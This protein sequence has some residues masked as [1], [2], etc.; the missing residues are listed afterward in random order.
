MH[1]SAKPYSSALP[2]KKQEGS[3]N[4]YIYCTFRKSGALERPLPESRPT[5][6]DNETIAS[7]AFAQVGQV[8]GANIM[9]G[10][11]NGLFAPAGLYS[12]EQSIATI[13]RLFDALN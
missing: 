4:I 10:V 1:T 6:V 11:G 2:F 9:G 5:F 12:R 7:W 3:Q 13:L 8:Q